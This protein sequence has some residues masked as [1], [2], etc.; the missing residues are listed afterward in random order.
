MVGADHPGFPAGSIAASLDV[1]MQSVVRLLEL[2]SDVECQCELVHGDIRFRIL[3]CPECVG[4]QTAGCACHG[5]AG[6][7]QAAA[8][9][10]AAGTSATASEI[11]CLAR[12]DSHCEFSIAGAG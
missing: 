4:R 6:M 7:V 8:D 11:Q 3:S 12:G 2:M 1:R 9:W 5:M 10:F